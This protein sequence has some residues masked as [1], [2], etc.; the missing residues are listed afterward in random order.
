M[1][2]FSR[3]KP[4]P[5]KPAAAAPA[6]A[7]PAQSKDVMRVFDSFGRETLISRQEWQNKV[8]PANLERVWDKP[9]ELFTMICSAL[10]DG[11][12]SSIVAATEHLFK[13][14]SDRYRAAFIWGIVLREEGRLD[15][16]EKIFRDFLAERGANGVIL[17]NLAKVYD[18]RQN[19]A[20]RDEILWQ[21]L[22]L[23]PNQDNGVSWF[24]F[25]EHQRGGDEAVRQGLEKLALQKGSWRAQLW[26][27]RMALDAKQLDPAI[28][29]YRQAMQHVERPVPAD[30]LMQ[31]SGDL[32]NHGQTK[33]LIELTEPLFDIQYHGLQVGNNLIKSHLDLGHLDIAKAL[34]DKL[35]AFNRP[36]WRNTLGF[37]EQEIAKARVAATPIGAPEALRMQM[38][39]IV[40]PIWLPASS[41]ACELFRDMPPRQFRVC[42]LGSSVTVPKAEQKPEHQMA[43]KRGRLTRAVPLFLAE[44]IYFGSPAQV[45]TLIP[46]VVGK[47]TGF[48]LAGAQWSDEDAVNHAKSTSPPSDYVV[49]VHLFAQAEPWK[50]EL[51][52]LRTNDGKN[53]A[54][55]SET[56]PTNAPGEEVTRLAANL[57]SLLRESANFAS[58]PFPPL[59]RAPAPPNFA[60]YLL[61]LEQLLAVRCARIEGVS[62]T[63]LNGEREIIDGNIQTCLASPDNPIPRLVLATTVSAMKAVR[64]DIPPEFSQKLALLQ[65]DNP[66]GQPVDSVVQRLL[67]V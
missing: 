38:V 18:K 50:I 48:V 14:D 3:K 65:R 47:S 33:E 39:S 45:E 59:Y 43:D 36:D 63:F 22:Q 62:T 49:T 7:N 67:S 31:M 35:F 30:F 42:F 10:N 54:R 15:E 4:E 25:L 58:L 12:R 1:G 16:A 13:T 6:S 23:D 2:F 41:P 51:R 27:A 5:P 60:Y 11:F 28:A 37:W 53:L 21:G 66:L 40:N 29:L 46:L 17:A 24:R 34:V 56:L 19:P 44:Q 57:L 8:L 9:D 20:K 61:R 64:P 32:G 55:L 26:L 52:L